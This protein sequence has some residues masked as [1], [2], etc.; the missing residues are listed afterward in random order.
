M[1]DADACE[2]KSGC[3]TP[4]LLP[5]N[6]FIG[7]SADQH[8]S[9]CLWFCSRLITHTWTLLPVSTSVSLTCG[10]QTRISVL[11]ILVG[12]RFLELTLFL[13]FF[14]SLSLYYNSQPTLHGHATNW[15]CQQTVP[16]HWSSIKQTKPVCVSSQNPTDAS[17]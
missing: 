15:Q 2:I 4:H 3:D 10:R 17:Q 16:G 11:Q 7:K 6:G 9:V 8:S 13:F 14:L 5:I 1:R 12:A